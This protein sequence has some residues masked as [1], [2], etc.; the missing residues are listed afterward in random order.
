MILVASVMPESSQLN[1]SV[2]C[3]FTTPVFQ[4]VP[5]DGGKKRLVCHGEVIYNRPVAVQMERRGS[6]DA[7]ATAGR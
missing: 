5:L 1:S 7:S 4:K 2:A 3:G 6:S